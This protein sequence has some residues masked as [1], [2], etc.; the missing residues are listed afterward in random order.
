MIRS[1]LSNVSDSHVKLFE[2]KRELTLELRFPAV[3][4]NRLNHRF[5]SITDYLRG[6][7]L[8]I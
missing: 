2:G 1:R 5:R 3:R 6:L 8:R 4:S 7:F